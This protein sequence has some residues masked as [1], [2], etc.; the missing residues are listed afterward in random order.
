MWHITHTETLRHSHSHTPKSFH[1]FKDWVFHSAPPLL[2][3]N[4]LLFASTLF[5]YIFLLSSLL[6][7]LQSS[8]QAFSFSPYMLH[9]PLLF[10]L[11]SLSLATHKPQPRSRHML[12]HLKGAQ[13][14]IINYGE[15][16]LNNFHHSLKTLNVFSF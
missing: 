3:S 10:S 13:P 15:G 4:Q 1:S 11:T 12:T 7:V 5:F 6:S 14:Q 9:I 16:K 2:S 8:D